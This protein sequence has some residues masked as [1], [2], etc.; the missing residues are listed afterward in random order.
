MGYFSNVL[1]IAKKEDIAAVPGYTSAPQHIKDVLAK[2][3][4]QARQE[5]TEQAADEII[6][7][8]KAVEQ[9]KARMR[10]RINAAKRQIDILKRQSANRDRALAYAQETDNWLPLAVSVGAIDSW[11]FDPEDRKLCVVPEG[12]Q[13]GQTSSEE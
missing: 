13:P 6:Q 12:W 4:E 8:L 11:N 3:M 2:K 9:N 10:D 7:I 1:A 5:A